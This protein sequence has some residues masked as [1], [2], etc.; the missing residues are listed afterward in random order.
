M[1]PNIGHIPQKTNPAMVHAANYLTYF[2]AL[3]RN[4]TKYL[5]NTS[6]G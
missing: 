1:V 2:K 3:N 6:E 5:A 4:G